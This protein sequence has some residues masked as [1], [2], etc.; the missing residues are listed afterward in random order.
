MLPFLL[1]SLL[2][3]PSVPAFDLERYE[4][5]ARSSTVGFDGTSTLHDFTGK[6]HAITGDLRA[7]PS[8][9][10]RLAG[11]AVWIEARTLDTDNRTRDGEMRDLLDVERC[12]QIV[13]R[14]DSVQRT[15]AG[16]A[17]E[18]TAQ[19]RFTIKG[20]EKPRVVRFHVDPVPPAPGEPA[21][22]LRVLGEARLCLTEHGIERPG[23]LFA[24]VD[25]AVRVWFDLRLR[26]VADP[27]VDA[28]V[29][30]LRVDQEFLPLA[31][32]NAP[33][34]T[35]GTDLLWRTDSSVLWE[36][37]LDRVWILEDAHGLASVDP[38]TGSSRPVG[39]PWGRA[40][41]QLS[42]PGITGTTR[43]TTFDE[44]GG[45]RTLRVR[46][47]EEAPSRLPTWALDPPSWA[48]GPARSAP[49]EDASGSRRR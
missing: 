20:V 4:I 26:P 27:G 49:R 5:D 17:R 48:N 21:G 36:R 10:S 12:P 43:T 15:R 16:G 42:Q 13:F 6:T 22:E 9:P 8:D 40:L 46:I 23:V 18:F 34:R 7:D 41:E 31:P 3:T 2:A 47:D 32:G 1:V 38:R 25:D 30:T 35:S 37:G 39:E 14:L 28:F 29:R 19:G 44:D 24:K 11:G 33:E 45:R